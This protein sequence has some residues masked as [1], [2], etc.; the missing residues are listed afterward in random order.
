MGKKS[1]MGLRLDGADGGTVARV[2]LSAFVGPD[3]AI[4]ERPTSA[5]AKL[6]AAAPDMLEA[7]R[8][9]KEAM[10][11]LVPPDWH[12]DLDDW[13]ITSINDGLRSIDAAIEAAS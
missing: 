11:R 8:F 7:L 5:N 9:A 13:E 1:N 6:M 3:S 4:V 2:A 12:D 10:T